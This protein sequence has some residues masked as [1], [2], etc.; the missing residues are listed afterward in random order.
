MQAIYAIHLRNTPVLAFKGH[1]LYGDSLWWNNAQGWVHKT[2]A[3]YFT[4]QE[5]ET[6]N[7]PANG[8]WV[9]IYV[10]EPVSEVR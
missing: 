8:E 7:L 6:M 3:D 10:N 5:K 9:K 1:P 4:P 2:Q